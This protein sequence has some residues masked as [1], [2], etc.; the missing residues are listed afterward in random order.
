MVNAG[1]TP[2]SRATRAISRTMA[3]A[4]SGTT[5]GRLLVRKSGSRIPYAWS[6]S[7]KFMATTLASSY[8]SSGAATRSTMSCTYRSNDRAFFFEPRATWPPRIRRERTGV[9]QRLHAA[10]DVAGRLAPTGNDTQWVRVHDPHM[11]AV[12]TV[13]SAE[14][15]AQ[16]EFHRFFEAEH[17]RMTTALYLITGDTSEAEELSQE[18][19]VRMYERWDRVRRMDSPTGYLYRT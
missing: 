2:A 18:A 14:T 5:T 16:T 6:F 1:P 13:L 3:G 12:R 17:R 7:E 4:S 9:E 10:T 8:S 15:S 19:M 11:A